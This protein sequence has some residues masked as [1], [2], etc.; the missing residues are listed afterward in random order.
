MSTTQN[1]DK[2]KRR[3]TATSTDLNVDKPN[4]RPTETSTLHLV[5]CMHCIVHTYILSVDCI[6]HISSHNS[7]HTRYI[8]LPKSEVSAIIIREFHEG[9]ETFL[10]QMANK[11]AKWCNFLSTLSVSIYCWMKEI[12][13]PQSGCHH[14]S[15]IANT[16]AKMKLNKKQ[17][18]R[19]Y[20]EYSSDIHVLGWHAIICQFKGFDVCS[21]ITALFIAYW[22]LERYETLRVAHAPGKSGSLT[23]GSL[24]SWWRG[25]VSRRMHNPQFCISDKWPMPRETDVS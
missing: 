8:S 16:W 12:K 17:N 11:S 24:W 18:E 2:P 13:E 6:L 5:H 9:F 20:E 7:L 25:N 23:S 21:L 22:P 14:V 15:S 3:L 4:R 10:I 1:F 19:L